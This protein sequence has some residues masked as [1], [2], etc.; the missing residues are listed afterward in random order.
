MSQAEVIGA[1]AARATA[2]G[3]GLG[4]EEVAACAAPTC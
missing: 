2:Q 4:I 1:V 3:L